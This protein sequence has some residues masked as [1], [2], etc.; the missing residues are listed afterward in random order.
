MVRNRWSGITTQVDAY[1][2]NSFGLYGMAGNVAEW[3]ADVYDQSL[4]KMLSDF[5]YYR[6][7]VYKAFD[8]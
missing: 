6:G 2:A 4:M 5:N 3:V 7:N 1:P 8:K